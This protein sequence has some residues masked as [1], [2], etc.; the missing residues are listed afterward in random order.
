MKDEWV[1]TMA[2]NLKAFLLLIAALAIMVATSSCS[3]K[4]VSV[5]ER[6]TLTVVKTDTILKD[7]VRIE[8]TK[9]YVDRWRDRLVVKNEAGDTVKD[10]VT[11]YVY[12]DKESELTELVAR[13]KSRCDSLQRVANRNREVKESKPPSVW[14]ESKSLLLSLVVV[15]AIYTMVRIYKKE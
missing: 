14:S 1:K 6:D 10:Y 11:E 13:Y 7:S 2:W 9:E 8:K 3:R 12:I 15:G 4:V 5:V